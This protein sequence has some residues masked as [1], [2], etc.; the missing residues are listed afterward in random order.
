MGYLIDELLE[1]TRMGALGRRNLG[2]QPIETVDWAHDTVRQFRRQNDA[3]TATLS[4]RGDIPRLTADTEKLTRA[5]TNELSNAF[6]Y[7]DE[8]QDGSF[9]LSADGESV[10]ICVTNHGIGMTAEDV[11]RRCDSCYREDAAKDIQGTGLGISL[12]LEILN[13]HRGIW[14]CK[15]SLAVAP[16]SPPSS[17]VVRLY[18]V[19]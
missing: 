17:H 4:V 2:L 1:L 14:M 9:K 6:K 7:S 16:M 13:A 18:D 3:R 11:A 10:H 8:S 12:A 15:A 5:L 19:S